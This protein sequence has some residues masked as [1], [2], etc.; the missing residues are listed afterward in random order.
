MT[1]EFEEIVANRASIRANFKFKWWT[2]IGWNYYYE[3]Q[4][5]VNG[6]SVSSELTVWTNFH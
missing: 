6:S 2:V 3:K 1:P 4:T 5:K